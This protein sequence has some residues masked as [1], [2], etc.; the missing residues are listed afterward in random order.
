MILGIY[1][2]QDS[3]KTVM[4]EK[5]VSALVKRGYEVA[6]VKHSPHRMSADCEGKDT[7]RHWK[8]GSD[9]VVFSS[10][11]ETAIF[12]HA[13]LPAD[14]ITSIINSEF[15]PD[16]IIMEGFKEGDFPKVAIGRVPPRKGTIMIDPK[17]GKLLEYV[18]NEVAV[19]RT[20]AQLPCLDCGKCGL[21]CKSLARAIVEGKRKVADCAELSDIRVEIRVNGRS[22]PT[23]R[24]VS[25]IVDST[26]RGMLGS[27]KG[28]EPKGTVEIR[29]EKG[30][31]A[32]KR[33]HRK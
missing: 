20:L 29:L 9:P 25:D 12:R 27:L 15:H 11:A 32:P 16:V 7:W 14:K 2:Y 21:D 6:S 33:V 18:E 23:G 19:E 30:T 4:V 1:G 13:K 28:Y 31:K 3:G 10:E 8:A 24:F 17:P 26:I 5:L 22:V